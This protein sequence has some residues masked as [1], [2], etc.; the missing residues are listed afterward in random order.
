VGGAIILERLYVW[1]GLKFAFTSS[2]SYYWTGRCWAKDESG[3]RILRVLREELSKIEAAYMREAGPGEGGKRSI[4]VV[5]GPSG[6]EDSGLGTKGGPA[7]RSKPAG[8]GKQPKVER[9]ERLI[10]VN[11]NSK[12][13]NIMGTCKGILLSARLPVPTGRAEGLPGCSERRHRL[14]DRRAAPASPPG[15]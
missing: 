9:E 11:F 6:D 2:G 7:I 13:S 1:T 4:A 5:D 12:M 8:G 3:G 14:A 10:N 15:E